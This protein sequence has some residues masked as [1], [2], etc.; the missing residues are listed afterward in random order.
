M[1]CFGELAAVSMHCRMPSRSTG[2]GA[3][4]RGQTHVLHTGDIDSGPGMAVSPQNE[5]GG[6]GGVGAEV[7]NAGSPPTPV[8]QTMLSWLIRRGLTLQHFCT[9]RRPGVPIIGGGALIRAMCPN[10]RAGHLV[11]SRSGG[12]GVGG[13]EQLPAGRGFNSRF[14]SSCPTS[15]VLCHSCPTSVLHLPTSNDFRLTKRFE[16]SSLTVCQKR[17]KNYV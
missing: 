1:F 17:K 14:V 13:V 6:E 15:A 5:E 16:I 7:W 8:E 10:K 3:K 2:N 9:T 12:P 11:R 4:F